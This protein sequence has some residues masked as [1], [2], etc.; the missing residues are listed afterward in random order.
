MSMFYSPSLLE[1]LLKYVLKEI[2]I[3]LLLIM[4]WFFSFPNANLCRLIYILLSFP[5]LVPLIS[6]SRTQSAWGLHQFLRY[7]PLL[8]HLH[9]FHLC[10]IGTDYSL[11]RWLSLSTVSSHKFYTHSHW[12]TFYGYE[13]HFHNPV[14]LPEL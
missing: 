6:Y 13:L 9:S 3:E 11:I 5:L 2:F 4:C 8:P 10:L 12:T 7:Q 14:P 1:N